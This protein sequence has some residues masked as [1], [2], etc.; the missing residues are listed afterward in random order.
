LRTVPGVDT[1]ESL[2]YPGLVTIA[3]NFQPGG[4][5]DKARRNVE[6]TLRA[7]DVGRYQLQK[8][9]AIEQAKMQAA[10]RHGMGPG[11]AEEIAK[12]MNASS[13]TAGKTPPLIYTVVTPIN[14]NEI[15]VST[16]AF[17]SDHSIAAMS[18]IVEQ[19]VVSALREVPGVLRV[20]VLG[21][22]GKRGS[23]VRYN[24]REAVAVSVVKNASANTLEVADAVDARIAALRASM[25]S[26]TIVRASGQAA[27]IREASHATTDALLLAVA[28]SV[29]VI[30]PFV[31]SR[32]A[33]L[34]CAS[35][36]PTSLLGAALVMRLFGFDLE[37]ITLLALALVVGVIVD[38]AIVAVEN[39]VRHIED[40]QTPL[41]AAHRANKELGRTLTATTLT[42][43]AVFVP[44]AGMP[45]TL[46]QFFR[47]FGITAS[48]A[49]L[50][51]LLVARSLSPA[52]AAVMLRSGKRTEVSAGP[53]YPLYMRLLRW[54]LLHRKRVIVTALAVF[55]G[56]L[57]VIPLIPKGF[58][59]HLDRDEFHI[60]F[61][62][63]RN[64]APEE[65]SRIAYALEQSVRRDPA[66]ADIYTTM[67]TRADEPTS[68]LLDVRLKTG[69]DAKTFAVENR[70]REH[71]IAVPG[72]AS[73]VED[74]PFVG[75][76][77]TKPFKISLV[78]NE[79]STL[80]AAG[81]KL[82]RK[83]RATGDY[84]DM[85]AVGFSDERRDAGFIQHRN[86]QR[87]V[88]ITADLAKNVQIGDASEQATSI[89][90]AMLPRGVSLSL[91]GVSSD[92]METFTTF[93]AALVFSVA[94]I[95]IVLISLFRSWLD[96]LA[97]GVALPLSVVGALL[98]LWITR[99]DFGMISLMGIVFLFGLVNKNAILLVDAIK[100]ERAAGKTRSEAVAAAGEHRL[101]PILMTTF[102]T[103][104]GMLPI[105]LGF[106]AGA[107][108]RQPMATAII[109]GLLTSTLLSLIVVPVVYTL[110]DDLRGPKRVSMNPFA[111]RDIAARLK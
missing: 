27:Y 22:P 81:R 30:W 5:L 75:S 23:H 11:A 38:D 104:L 25:P 29:F 80:R 99:T 68:G 17:T 89:A 44:I 107:E 74:V 3:L 2:T 93:G 50:F 55:I 34:I 101:R 40:G 54:S 76:A 77:A 91:G 21:A 47:P 105:A 102:A 31:R 35:A 19:R 13:P 59:P 98:A 37:T 46:G 42:I 28:L 48:A 106:G 39:I 86:G 79:L 8:L 63:P 18:R 14:L 95:L 64:T 62:A 84:I 97:I 51:S 88:S 12:Y 1:M 4:A 71:L 7:A 43:V 111:G 57:A 100:R 10:L 45:G 52:L 90:H 49:V 56:G 83:L 41:Q 20:D 92:A 85:Q 94:A 72:V 36:I 32:R 53:R 60:V 96:P 69:R 9:Q 82:E 33:T 108:L 58:I 15:A 16:Y 110:F 26:T 70:V 61:T 103:I 78:G 65:M 87:A 66:A 6:D 24:G 109:G 73:S 67:G